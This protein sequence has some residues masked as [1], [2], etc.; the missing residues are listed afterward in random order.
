MS[1]THRITE[2]LQAWNAGDSRALDELI[3]LV[4]QELKKI[5]RAYMRREK[6][7]H[8]LQTTALVVEAFIR[9]V[10]GEPINWQNRHQFYAIVAKRMR[11]VLID[12]AR[13]KSASRRGHGAEHVNID[14][15]FITSEQSEELLLLHEALERLAELDERKAKIV[16]FRY[17][18]GFTFK[19]VAEMLG[20]SLSTVEREWGF[21][22][23]WLRRELT[24]T[25]N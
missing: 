22:R 8:T 14:D 13:Q 1:D 9:L 15:V 2:L 7:G 12:Y 20:V 23:A 18:G 10:Q 3:P 16:E 11:Q 25:D 21:A 6:Q 24:P 4:D 5:A 19:D 17:F